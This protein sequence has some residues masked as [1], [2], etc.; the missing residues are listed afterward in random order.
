MLQETSH[1]CDNRPTT[2][3]ATGY[4]KEKSFDLAHR[5][6]RKDDKGKGGIGE[7]KGK[8]GNVISFYTPEILDPAPHVLFKWY[9]KY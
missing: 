1:L 2:A 4:N 5:L 3:E 8:W 7:R 6:T 9:N